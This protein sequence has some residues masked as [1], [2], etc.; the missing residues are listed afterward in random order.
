MRPMSYWVE[1]EIKLACKKENPNWD[2]KSFDYGCA[3]Y[4][5]AL[6]AYLSLLDDEHSG[7][8]WNITKN[9]LI[10]LMEGLPLTAITED[11][12]K[13]VKLSFKHDD[14]TKVYQCPRMFSLFKDVD[15]EGNIT[16]S[17]NNRCYCVDENGHSYGSGM[18]TDL[19]DEMFPIT[20]PYYPK[21]QKY[22]FYTED[23]LLT[24]GNGDY[25]HRA[26]FYVKTPEGDK[27]EINKFYKDIDGDLK[28]ISKERY[29]KDKGV[30]INE[31]K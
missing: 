5:S 20:L 11:D 28:E 26:I 6:K 15:K 3:C 27:I 29:Y 8:S 18:I 31:N 4:E 17:D 22:I 12:F 16:Y 9:I 21:A 10:R 2:G 13:D 14:G 24:P 19:C 30:F 1:N 23:F 7:L 25:D